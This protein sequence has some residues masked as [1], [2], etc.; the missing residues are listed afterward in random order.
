MNTI[1]TIVLII[2]VV[3]P[4]IL[5]GIH[6]RKVVLTLATTYGHSIS[7]FHMY[8]LDRI[9]SRALRRNQYSNIRLIHKLILQN[10]LREYKEDVKFAVG[11]WNAECLQHA[12]DEYDMQVA[13]HRSCDY[14][15]RTPNPVTEIERKTSE[16]Y[17]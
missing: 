9:I 5:F 17:K 6:Y 16:C 11:E 4:C 3:A 14:A 1:L 7:D 12:M 10:A 15:I 13:L 8:M 2:M